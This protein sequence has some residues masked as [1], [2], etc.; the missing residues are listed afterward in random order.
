LFRQPPAKRQRTSN[1]KPAYRQAGIK[2][3]THHF[4]D[5]YQ[6]LG[7]IFQIRWKN[8]PPQPLWALAFYVFPYK[9]W[10]TPLLKRVSITVVT[11]F[12]GFAHSVATNGGYMDWFNPQNKQPVRWLPCTTIHGTSSGGP[13]AD[14]TSATGDL[15]RTQRTPAYP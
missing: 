7:R 1:N 6:K 12:W 3:K 2:P 11:V 13:A 5:N 8:L 15:R 9:I 10:I 4:F 14:G